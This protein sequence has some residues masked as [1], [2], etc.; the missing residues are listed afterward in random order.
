MQIKIVPV[1][2]LA[3]LC[4]LF[5]IRTYKSQRWVSTLAKTPDSSGRL[6]FDGKFLIVRNSNTLINE[7]L[8]VL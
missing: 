6:T 7:R 1:I 4:F 8:N 3:V 2:A 5:I